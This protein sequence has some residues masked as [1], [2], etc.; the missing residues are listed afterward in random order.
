MLKFKLNKK[1]IDVKSCWDDLTYGDYLRTLDLK[2]R[3]TAE[4]ISI[5]TGIATEQLKKSNIS[6]LEQL[7]VAAQFMNTLPEFND[8][9][10]KVGPYQLPKDIALETL[11][12]F[13]DMRGIMLK[14]GNTP[15]ELLKSYIHYVAIYVQKIRDGE[16]DSEK[17]E[18][19]IPEISGYQAKE[20][21]EAGAFFLI[22]LL[23]LINGTKASSQ[24]PTETRKASTG[25]RSV[26]RSGRTQ[27]STRSRKK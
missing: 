19:M 16:Y 18:D 20:V 25:K 17:A 4:V 11:A 1:S 14:T 7:I 23:D 3:D 27:S 15:I 8:K 6:G 24:N 13:E 9:P 10:T 2:P 21:I 12:Q 26:K 22:K 5:I